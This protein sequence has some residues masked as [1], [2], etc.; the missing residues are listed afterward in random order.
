MRGH[1]KNWWRNSSRRKDFDWYSRFKL[2]PVRLDKL[3]AKTDLEEPSTLNSNAKSFRA[4]SLQR[5]DWWWITSSTT[6]A[7]YNFDDIGGGPKVDGVVVF[8]VL[9][10]LV[11]A[12]IVIVCKY[13]LC[14]DRDCTTII[15]KECC[16]VSPSEE[17]RISPSGWNSRRTPLTASDNYSFS[18]EATRLPGGRSTSR[19][20][21]S[22]ALSS[23]SGGSRAAQNSTTTLDKPPG[24]SDVILAD[25]SVGP[26]QFPEVNPT[27]PDSPPPK[28]DEGNMN[29]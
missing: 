20:Q 11:V 10:P 22:L 13:H 4:L 18:A 29:Y 15:C 12:A 14:E 23:V 2:K 1:D 9:F 17:R 28:C 21:I 3:H 26:A 5:Y 27:I 7:P 6:E 25:F 8:I 24:Y 16:D 19:P